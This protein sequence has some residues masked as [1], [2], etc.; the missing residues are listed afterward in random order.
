MIKFF[1][2]IR[3]RL[4]TENKF[5]KYL[6]YAIGEILLVV[7]GIL[8]ALSINNWNNNNND[9][10]LEKEYL[11]RLQKDLM[12][13]SKYFEERT[14]ESKKSVTNY[15]LAIDKMYEPNK[16]W[17][18]L[19]EFSS[20]FGSL[21]PF[22]SIH[23]TLQ[24]F[25]FTELTNAGNLDLITKSEVKDSLINYYKRADAVGKH[26]QEANE[27]SINSL[28]TYDANYPIGSLGFEQRNTNTDTRQYVIEMFNNPSSSAFKSYE[29]TIG[30]YLYKNE[31]FIEY[32]TQMNA[33]ALRLVKMIENQN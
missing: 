5:S 3:Q 9:R 16:G 27:W 17:D 31:I 20:G 22:K 13:D 32:F 10:I 11:K 7:L 19:S 33:R 6:L 29:Q 24:D 14:E 15:F 21:T 30:I 18:D 12:A 26:V 4:L 23:L 28:N 1:R 8:I 25:T 2:K